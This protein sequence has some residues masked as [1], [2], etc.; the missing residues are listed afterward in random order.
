MENAPYGLSFAEVEERRQ[1]GLDNREIAPPTKSVGQIFASNIFTYINAIFTILGAGI[2]VAGVVSKTDVLRIVKDLGFMVI[3]IINTAIGIIQELRSKKTLDKMALLTERKCAVVREG[4]EYS[5]GVHDTVLGDVVIFRAGSQ[6][7]ADASVLSGEAIVNESLI[8]G[9]AD[10]IKKSEGEELIS[11][12]FV[13]SGE[14]AAVLTA[15][16]ENSFASKLTLEAKRAKK[17]GKSEMMRSLTR[18]VTVIGI[19][20]IPLGAGMLIKEMNINGTDL[21]DAVVHTVAALVGMIPEGLY[22]LTSLALVT[23]VVRLTNTFF[24]FCSSA[25][26]RRSC[27]AVKP[28]KSS[29]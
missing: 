7:F 21:H 14:C 26:I 4:K 17:R 11:G 27:G 3:V 9:E 22:L 13:M 10:E 20:I 28:R 12:S 15:V 2:I 19:L 29:K 5:V 23:S 25:S 24:A 16:G 8:T 6:I 18:L 1:N